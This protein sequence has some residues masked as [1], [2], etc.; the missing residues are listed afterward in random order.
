MWPF[1]PDAQARASNIGRFPD[2]GTE[3][4]IVAA[5]PHGPVSV[6]VFQ[7]AVDPLG[8]TALVVAQVFC[9]PIVGAPLCPRLI[10]VRD[11]AAA[12]RVYIDDRYMTKRIAPA[13]MTPTHTRKRG[14]L[15]RYYVT[16]GVIRGSADACPKAKRNS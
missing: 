15:Y 11:L 6:T 5:H 4:F 10:L 2:C 1:D 7:A 14:R 9:Q 12:P 16:N 3:H 8:D 13:A